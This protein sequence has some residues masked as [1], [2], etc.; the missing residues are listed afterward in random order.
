MMLPLAMLKL[1][2]ASSAVLAAFSLTWSVANHREGMLYR[3]WS[4]YVGYLDRALRNLF[5]PTRGQLIAGA[6]TLRFSV[7]YLRDFGQ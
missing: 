7:A 4:S 2:A 1:S 5:L 3:A 6:N